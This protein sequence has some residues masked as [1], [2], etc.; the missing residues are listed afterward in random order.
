MTKKAPRRGAV[1]S[2]IRCS[3]QPDGHVDL[4]AFAL[5][6]ERDRPARSVDEPA[7]LIGGFHRLVVEG[8]D[9]VAGLHPRA[10]RRAFDFLDK[11]AAFR[12]DLLALLPGEGAHRDAELAR[13]R[14]CV[15]AGPGDFFGR[16][17]AERSAQLPR[18]ALAP[19]LEVYG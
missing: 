5:Y 8:E 1:P 12:L 7:Q 17:L 9:H 14:S 16:D 10:R 13:A 11:Q 2:S 15:V 19:Y 3:A 6:Q 4:V 18:F